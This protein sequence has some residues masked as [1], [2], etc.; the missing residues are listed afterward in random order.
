LAPARALADGRIGAMAELRENR[1]LA[2]ILAADIVGYS[3]LMAANEGG[4]LARL[5]A[6]RRDFFDGT[7]TSFGGRIVKTTGDGFLVEFASVVDAVRCAIAVQQGM[8]EREGDRSDA[9][10]M[11]FRIGINLGDVIAEGDDIYGD[12]VNVAARLE[13]LAQPGG[14]CLSRAARDQVRDKF[15]HEVRDL[16]ELEVKN[17]PRPVRV[18]E[19]VLDRASGSGAK[20]AAKDAAAEGPSIVVLPFTNMSGDPEQ[21]YFSDGISEDIITDLSKIP[22]LLVIARNSS[23]AFKGKAINVSE[24]CKQ[25]RVK[26]A[27]EGSVRKADQRVRITAQLIEGASGGHLW[28]ERYDRQLTDIFDVQDEVTQQIVGAL[29]INL[30]KADEKKLAVTGTRNVEAHDCFLRGREV[31]NTTKMSKDGIIQA[32][33]WFR[34]AI[35]IDP[36]YAAGYGGLA[37]TYLLDHQNHWGGD[38]KEALKLGRHFADEALARDRNDPF[39]RCVGALTAMFEKDYERWRRETDAALVLNPN[40]PLALNLRGAIHF[41]AGEP[42]K[43]IPLIEQ[44]IRLDPEFRQ[45]YLHF[46]GMAYYLDGQYDKAVTMFRERIELNPTTD[47]SRGYL[48]SALG[49]LGKREQAGEIWREL[50]EINPHYLPAEHLSRMPLRPVDTER[51]LD[52]MRKAGLP[53]A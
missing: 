9:E 21:E 16:G 17:I 11:Q 38:P 44:A 20:G 31:F 46:L 43:A 49:H 24:I 41:A 22:G 2:A 18:F 45:H 23:F 40:F 51:I 53:I 30:S 10:R 14:I 4:T 39:L 52:G 48:A 13:A 50:K 37:Q 35:E 32:S 33:G 27:L 28:A 47:L 25:F 3:R 6:L 7:L 12:G 5:K 15:D 1:R 8:T 26:Y 42:L 19:V 29:K 34:R 36:G